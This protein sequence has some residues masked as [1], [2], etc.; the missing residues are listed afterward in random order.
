MT[1]PKIIFIS[2]NEVNLP[3]KLDYSRVCNYP[4]LASKV[5]YSDNNSNDL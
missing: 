4:S 2:N 5:T 3:N 1:I